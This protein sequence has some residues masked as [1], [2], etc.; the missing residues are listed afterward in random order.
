MIKRTIVIENA[1][2]LSLRLNQLVVRKEG[3]S[4]EKSVPIEDIAVLILES[5]QIT[6]TNALLSTL[7]K[8]QVAVI[9]CEERHM[10]IGLWM[11][12]EGNTLQ[13]ARFQMQMEV[14]VP[15]KKQVWSQLIKSKIENQSEVL[16]YVGQNCE[17]L[18]RWAKEVRSGDPDNLEARAA[19]YYWRGLFGD[20]S[21]KR[22]RFGEPPNHL[23]NYGYAI[24]RAM[25]ARAL[26]ASGLMP[27]YGVH[28]RN[29]YNAYCLADDVMEPFRPF[30]DWHIIKIAENLDIP[31]ELT[32]QWKIELLKIPTLDIVIK[33]TKSPMLVA[34]SKISASLVKVYE[35]EVKK[36]D[37]PSFSN[38]F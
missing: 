19:S 10:P 34:I 20:M 13:S 30:I 2:Y 36:L 15:L 11:P 14:S 4:E 9:S 7:L 25:V 28:H 8:E 23:L 21:F 29:Q 1:S 17:P 24:L 26:V 6:I 3:E 37:L 22:E 27:T 32:R 31:D 5:Q 35:G 16:K 18:I 33:G 12:L 38:V